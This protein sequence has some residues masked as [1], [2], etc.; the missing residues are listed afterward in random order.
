MPPGAKIAL[1]A[2]FMLE[3][4]LKCR[5]AQNY[6]PL[7]AHPSCRLK[8]KRLNLGYSF[9]DLA[10]F[11][12]YPL[13]GKPT[14]STSTTRHWTRRVVVYGDLWRNGTH[15]H[16]QKL[17]PKNQSLV[18]SRFRACIMAIHGIILWSTEGIL[19]KK[20]GITIIYLLFQNR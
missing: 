10:A 19:Y 4:H 12:K 16:D 3:I 8:N 6:Q 11:T 2:Q 17:M 7:K 18:S 14:N 20:C 15:G 13:G 5:S 1:K 9:L